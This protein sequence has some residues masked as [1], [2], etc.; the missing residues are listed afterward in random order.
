MAPC[1]QDDS[2]RPVTSS[3]SFLRGRARN[4][5]KSRPLFSPTTRAHAP[6]CCAQ[7][8]AHR[9]GPHKLR[10]RAIS[11]ALVQ[12]GT[13][14]RWNSPRDWLRAK[15]SQRAAAN[16]RP[17]QI[18]ARFAVAPCVLP[19]C[20]RRARTSLRL[21]SAPTLDTAVRVIQRWS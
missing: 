12:G 5:V 1:K 7:R 14:T 20:N 19:G 6:L 21:G 2:A 8:C 10:R 16:T 3:R 15:N 13:T 17:G 11:V 18:Q 4:R 9:R